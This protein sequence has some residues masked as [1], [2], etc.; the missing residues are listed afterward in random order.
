MSS[1]LHT[2]LL[3]QEANLWSGIL[4]GPCWETGRLVSAQH[5][6]GD[7]T[8]SGEVLQGPAQ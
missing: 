5:E 4:V 3:L 8:P 6:Q 7:S 1:P 2:P